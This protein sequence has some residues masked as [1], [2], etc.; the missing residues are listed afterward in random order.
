VIALFGR[1]PSKTFF[2]T[3]IA[4]KIWKIK[5]NRILEIIVTSEENRYTY[6]NKSY[7][8]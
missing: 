7:G 5:E 6:L 2:G 8:T 3:N 1:N 4:Y